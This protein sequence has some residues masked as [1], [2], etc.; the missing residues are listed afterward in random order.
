MKK[1]KDFLPENLAYAL[2]YWYT[3]WLLGVFDPQKAEQA[4][5]EVLT[6]MALNFSREKAMSYI[7]TYRLN[8]SKCWLSL[9]TKP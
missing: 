2:V 8:D 1:P 4:A 5:A 7:Q 6:W 9:E 3:H